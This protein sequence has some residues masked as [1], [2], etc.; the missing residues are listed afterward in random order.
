MRLAIGLLLALNVCYAIWVVV[1]PSSS[2]SQE[3]VSLSAPPL[4]LVA[5]DS[6]ELQAGGAAPLCV[7][8]GPFADEHSLQA[9]ASGILAD[10][11]WSVAPRELPAMVRHRAYIPAVE[12]RVEAQQQLKAV[13]DII[14]RLEVDIDS[15]LITAG[16]L[17][18]AVSLGVFAEAGNAQRVQEV[19]AGQPFAVL[20]RDEARAQSEYWL[21]IS[22]DKMFDF[23]R[24]NDFETEFH[25]VIA[26]LEQNVCET[27]A[28]RE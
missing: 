17:D 28:Q 21:R 10:N 18:N 12:S 4:Q 16:E 13:R 9:F 1:R 15:Y 6:I 25:D 19:L 20:I 24:K 23:S 5:A 11:L 27:I 2:E 3:V 8:L 14:A 26:M 7:E 22:T